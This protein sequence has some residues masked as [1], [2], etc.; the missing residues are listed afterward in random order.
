MRQEAAQSMPGPAA[1]RPARLTSALRGLGLAV[2]FGVIGL[3]AWVLVDGRNDAWKHARLASANLVRAL[4]HDIE[5]NIG[6][7]DLSI[8][9]TIAALQLP[10]IE[11]ASPELRQ[12]AL[13]DRA[14]TAEYLGSILVIGPD[15]RPTASSI[16]TT[17]LSL[18]L[19]DRDYFT[20]HRDRPDAGLFISRPFRSRLRGGDPSIAISR[21][22]HNA[23]GGFA[24]VV[25]GTL[26]L[27]YFQDRFGTL[28][29]GRDGAVSLFR[30]DGRLLVRHPFRP[31]EID[32]DLSG[33][34]TVQRYM[35]EDS[36]S[37]VG[38]GGLDGVAR[39]YTFRR[40]GNLP[41][42]VSVA[43]AVEDIFADWRAKAF[44]TGG[45]LAVLNALILLLAV[46]LRREMARRAA[47]E[48][49][50][51]A[52]A[53]TDALTGL[54]NRRSL[55][56][57]LDREWGRALREDLPISLLL[58][59]VDR[60]K[61]FNDRYGHPAG[62]ECLRAV[63]AAVS[64]AVQ[65]HIDLAARY[66]GEEIAVLLPNTE[67]EGARHIA[68]RLRSAIERLGLTH[69]GSEVG[70]VTASL[71]CATLRPTSGLPGGAKFLVSEADRALYAAKRRGRNRV[72][73]LS[74]LRAMAEEDAAA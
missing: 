24:G 68:E 45:I 12:L 49:A 72:V 46:L 74:Q 4:E 66:G 3:G 10:E 73:S 21:R 14:A 22:L 52:A 63:A 5:R 54:A 55:D 8:Q 1:G 27:A 61:A 16:S 71:G 42:V 2:A 65:R 57:A 69:E 33:A 40:I 18:N 32:R 36:G 35:A 64:R 20:V 15:G 34:D 29:V 44:I 37:F 56:A 30:R 39:L 17:P 60:F 53:H 6:L 9:G 19:S 28:D 41:L 13:F 43:T 31:V 58:L 7:Y 38:H 50:M 25:V 48:Q 67:A 51:L 11:S 47:A 23:A 62:D 70:I 59:D 26:R